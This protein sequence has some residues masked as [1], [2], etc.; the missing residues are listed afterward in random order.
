MQ[1]ETI[2]RHVGDGVQAVEHH[3]ELVFQLALV[4]RFERSLRG[5]EVRADGVVREV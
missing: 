2:D 5:G 1:F 3:P 4:V